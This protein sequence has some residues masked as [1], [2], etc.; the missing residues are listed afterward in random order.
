M[1]IEIDIENCK[2]CPYSWLHRNVAGDT[3]V[4]CDKLSDNV[5]AGHTV[6]E[7]CPLAAET[8]GVG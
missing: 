1:K 2:E 7:G 6:F 4:V 8:E 3:S 5:G